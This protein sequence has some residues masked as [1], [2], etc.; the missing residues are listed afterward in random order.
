MSQPLQEYLN[1]KQKQVETFF[2]IINGEGHYIPR[3]NPIPKKEY[4][5][6]YPIEDKVTLWSF[7]QKG[8]NPDKTHV[9]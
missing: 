3:L 2:K 1:N 6:W 4:E 8:D 9:K 7:N 5:Q